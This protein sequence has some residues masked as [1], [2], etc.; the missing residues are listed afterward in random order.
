VEVNVMDGRKIEKILNKQTGQDAIIEIDDILSQIFYTDPD[1]LT[2]CEKNIVFI[3]ELEREV[4]NGGFSQYFSNYSGDYAIE[5]LTALKTIK[6]K[7]F[8]DLLNNAIKKFPDG[9][10]PKD[11]DEREELVEKMENEND[12]LWDSLDEN[13][14][15]YEEDIYSLMIDYIRN[16]MKEFR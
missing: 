12:S 7:I 2:Q 10:A 4:N 13:F 5:T 8:F 6:S 11:R 3:E 16:N 1:V 15:Q 9:T 14:L